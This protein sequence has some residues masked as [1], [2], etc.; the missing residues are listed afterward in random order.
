MTPYEQAS[1]FYRTR[2]PSKSESLTKL[3]EFHYREGCVLSTSRVFVLARVRPLTDLIARSLPPWPRLPDAWFIE[4]LAGS[5]V[6]ALTAMPFWLP[7]VAFE[8]KGRLKV[9]ATATLVNRLLKD[10]PLENGDANPLLR[11][12]RGGHRQTS[13]TPVTHFRSGEFGQGPRA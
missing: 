1:E 12:R 10:A 8:R 5:M 6:D 11:G 13:S 7:Y 3:L 9:Y 4:Y 2:T